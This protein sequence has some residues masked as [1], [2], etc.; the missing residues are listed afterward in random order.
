MASLT[1]WRNAISDWYNRL[2]TP[3]GSFQTRITRT[4]GQ[5]V[6]DL[7]QGTA[8]FYDKG[9]IQASPTASPEVLR[10]ESLHSLFDTPSFN[11]SAGQI[12]PLV[13]PEWKGYLTNNPQYQKE[14]AAEGLNPILAN[15]GAALDISKGQASNA[16]LNSIAGLLDDQKKQQFSRLVEAGKKK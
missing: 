11:S 15:E 3:V 5:F 6:N 9:S 7:P 16:L 2:T 4:P 14:I 10:H 8:A 1:E 12:A 13:S